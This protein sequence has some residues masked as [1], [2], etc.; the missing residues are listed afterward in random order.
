MNNAKKVPLRKC[1]ACNERKEKK[2]LIRLVVFE[3]KIIV[4]KTLKLN[5]RGA[6][7]C[8]DAKCVNK[9][10]K[11]RIID[12]SLEIKTTDD[13]YDSILKELESEQ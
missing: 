1:V 12:R 8:K 9:A 11:S 3:D 2:E 10:K 6:Y 4:D 5:G 7:I 13:L